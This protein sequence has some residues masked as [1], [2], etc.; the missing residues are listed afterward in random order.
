VAATEQDSGSEEIQDL[1]MGEMIAHTRRLCE[2]SLRLLPVDGASVV[3]RSG[4]AH[5]EL[6][7]AT[8]SWSARLEDLQFVVGEGPCL[9]AYQSRQSVLEPDLG[10]S[11]ASIRWPGFAREA[12]AAGTGA[13]FAFPLQVGAVPFGVLELYRQV[14]GELTDSQLATAILIVDDLVR[15]V[16]QDL[17]GA[18]IAPVPGDSPP[19]LGRP[20]VPQATGMIAVQ[21][22]IST[23]GALAELRATAFTQSRPVQAV[24]EEV[25][26]RRISFVGRRI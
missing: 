10:G 17:T 3:V 9:D 19:L 25:L 16:L 7:H 21:M 22:N 20:E 1:G 14:P 26:A 18:L 15:A 4:V 6:V 13:V 2:L 24:A 8:D 12:A 5:K 23:P 11:A